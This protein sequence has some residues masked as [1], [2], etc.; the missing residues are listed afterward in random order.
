MENSAGGTWSVGS[1]WTEETA[2]TL[3][4]GS[5]LTVLATGEAELK[6]A[7]RILND[8]TINVAVTGALGIDG[9]SDY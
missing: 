2:A 8:G 1:N 7:D 4:L 9:G 6:T 3:T 5:H